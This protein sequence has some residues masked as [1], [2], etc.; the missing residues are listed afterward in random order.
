MK[1]PACVEEPTFC[2][3]V[4]DVPRMAIV[5]WTPEYDGEGRMVNSDPNPVV[6]WFYCRRCGREWTATTAAGETTIRD[7]GRTLPT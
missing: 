5:E 3:I 6:H 7:A 2:R 1:H 4:R